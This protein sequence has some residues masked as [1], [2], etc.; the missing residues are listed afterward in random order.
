MGT[1]ERLGMGT[2]MLACGLFMLLVVVVLTLAIM[3]LVKH[4]LRRDKKA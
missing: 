4:L 2:M 1:M 3:A